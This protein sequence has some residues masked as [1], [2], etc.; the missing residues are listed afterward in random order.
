LFSSCKK[1]NWTKLFWPLI[2][3]KLN[4]SQYKG[5]HF[6]S[7]LHSR[8]FSTLWTVKGAE[9]GVPL[10]PKTPCMN[11]FMLFWTEGSSFFFT[12][13]IFILQFYRLRGLTLLVISDV[14]KKM[15]SAFSDLQIWNQN[16]SSIPPSPFSCNKFH[17]KGKFYR[18][19]Y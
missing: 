16:T 19:K 11:Y 3:S 6:P 10:Q 13:T 18:S 15:L 17:H 4:K 12:F 8:P 7:Y 2:E 14:W 1:F 5:T 9:I